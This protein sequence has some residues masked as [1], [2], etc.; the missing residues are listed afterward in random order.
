MKHWMKMLTMLCMAVVLIACGKTVEEQIAEQMDLG[1]RY[2]EEM[3]YE[4][5]IV[6]FQKVIEL[7]DKNVEAYLGLSQAYVALGDTEQALTVLETGYEKTQ[8]QRIQEKLDELREMLGINGSG[9]GTDADGSGGGGTSDGQPG[10]DGSQ[11]GESGNGENPAGGQESDGQAGSGGETGTESQPEDETG[12]SPADEEFLTNLVEEMEEILNDEDGGDSG[13][14][15]GSD[16]GGEDVYEQLERYRPQMRGDEPIVIMIDDDTGIGVYRTRG[17]SL[18][19]YYGGYVDGKR[20]GRGVWM[21]NWSSAKYRAVG[22]WADD[23]PNGEQVERVEMDIQTQILE[24][25]VTDGSWQ[26][27]VRLTIIDKVGSGYTYEFVGSMTDSRWDVIRDDVWPDN[28]VI[29]EDETNLPFFVV[30]TQGVPDPYGVYKM[31]VTE[32]SGS[33]DYQ[34]GIVGFADDRRAANLYNCGMACK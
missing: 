13:E 23:A 1:E 8:D 7:D 5:A 2:L 3:K 11:G 32:Y 34:R 12:V 6:A 4:E 14:N 33:L 21:G 15:G 20:H 26:G 17:A 28:V 9:S 31:N 18:M 30:G 22:Q 19:I 24:G 27:P 25:Q 10:S 16:E 29:A